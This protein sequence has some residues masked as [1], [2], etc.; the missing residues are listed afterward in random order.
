[1]VELEVDV[2]VVPDLHGSEEYIYIYVYVCFVGLERESGE[3]GGGER[4]SPGRRRETW[5]GVLLLRWFL[6]LKLS[7][8]T[9]PSFIAVFVK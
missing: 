3:C 2:S 8:V 9:P 6:Q 1:M 7:E 4:K 5:D